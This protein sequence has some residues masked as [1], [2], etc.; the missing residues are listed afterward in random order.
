MRE[1]Q[2]WSKFWLILGQNCREKLQLAGLD[3]PRR[4][5]EALLRAQEYYIARGE[6][7]WPNRKK[8]R[9]GKTKVEI[10]AVKPTDKCNTCGELG[11]WSRDC[12]RVGDLRSYDSKPT[13]TPKPSGASGAPAAPCQYCQKKHGSTDC[14]AAKA[15]MR[16]AGYVT[17]G[18]GG[19]ASKP[20]DGDSAP[21]ASKAPDAK[22]GRGK[23]R[24][25]GRGRGKA[26]GS[27]DKVHQVGVDPEGAVT[28]SPD[29]PY[30]YEEEDSEEEI[31]GGSSSSFQ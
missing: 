31:L 11:H 15:L 19:A 12:V 4:L 3:D 26:K 27:G 5:S 25:R 14:Y 30:G 24:G 28:D 8:S 23:G 21:P 29:H 18:R 13:S 9:D 1:Y 2:L 6:S 7:P 22:R 20:K 17:S 16:K 10:N